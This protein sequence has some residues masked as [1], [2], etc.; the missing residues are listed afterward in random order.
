MK[1]SSVRL[2]LLLLLLCGLALGNDLTLNPLSGELVVTG[3]PSLTL[4]NPTTLTSPQV[5]GRQLYLVVWDFN[6]PIKSCAI[7]TGWTIQLLNGP[8]NYANVG[9]ADGTLTATAL[10]G[11]FSAVQNGI[12]SSLGGYAAGYDFKAMAGNVQQ[13]SADLGT[14]LDPTKGQFLKIVDQKPV[15]VPPFKLINGDPPIP[16]FLGSVQ[17]FAPSGSSFSCPTPKTATLSGID[18]V[19]NVYMGDGITIQPPLDFLNL[20]GTKDWRI[21]IYPQQVE[22]RPGKGKLSFS[23]SD[24]NLKLV[25]SLTGSSLSLD[26]GNAVRTPQ[27]IVVDF[28]PALTKL[29]RTVPIP[30]GGSNSGCALILKFK[31]PK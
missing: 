7:S 26:Q 5:S 28:W 18:Y 15:L 21:I 2:T 16:I 13:C 31:P 25:C 1:L 8:T 29:P 6:G 4:V 17:I 9:V 11:T 12:T 22:I 20:T 23:V 19:S 30:C 10:Q 3:T 27:Q 24:P 14:S